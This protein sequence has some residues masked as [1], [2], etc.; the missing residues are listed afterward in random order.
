MEARRRSRSPEKR[1]EHH[2][3]RERRDDHQDFP[4]GNTVEASRVLESRRERGRSRSRS[5]ERDRRPRREQSWKG[6]WVHDRYHQR[7]IKSELSRGVLAPRAIPGQP[8]EDA[9]SNREPK[10]KRTAA[11]SNERSN[12]VNRC[13]PNKDGERVTSD[14]RGERLEKARQATPELRGG[15]GPPKTTQPSSRMMGIIQL[16]LVK[17][18]NVEEA[19]IAQIAARCS[20]LRS[21][22]SFQ[23]EPVAKRVCIGSGQETKSMNLEAALQIANHQTTSH[24]LQGKHDVCGSRASVTHVSVK[25]YN[26]LMD[27]VCRL[28]KA[29]D[30]TKAVTASNEGQL[31][32]ALGHLQKALDETKAGTARSERREKLLKRINQRHNTWLTECDADIAREAAR[33]NQGQG[34]A[35]G[36]SSSG[37]PHVQARKRREISL[38]QILLNIKED[39]RAQIERLVVRRLKTVIEVLDFGPFMDEF[40]DSFVV[41]MDRE[42]TQ[43]SEAAQRRE[44]AKQTE[45][46]NAMQTL[47]ISFPPGLSAAPSFGASSSALFHYPTDRL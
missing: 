8:K 20:R 33:R 14:D 12:P 9:I 44:K 13:S 35:N 2:S 19:Q 30:E 40:I 6:E 10:F 7:E 42:K 27:E 15:Y 24:E 25:S 17:E 36:A 39:V 21:D 26:E 29:L 41:D 28:Q 4:R 22:S 31:M 18:S 23:G 47:Q 3:Y 46:D 37:D 11:P 16:P 43:M 34:K 32:A 5:R 45:H 1:D 38:S